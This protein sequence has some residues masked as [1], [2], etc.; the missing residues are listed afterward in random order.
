MINHSVAQLIF[1]VSTV[2]FAICLTNGCSQE[3]QNAVLLRRENLAHLG[4]SYLEWSKVKQSSPGNAEEFTQWMLETDN[5]NIL[6][7]ARNSLIEGDVIMIWNGDLTDEPANA[8]YVVA[9]EAPTPAKGGYVVMGDASVKLMTAKEFA[10]STM[11]P[12][13]Y[14]E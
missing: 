3:Q 7:S 9:F 6:G 10:A 8:G 2:L 13:R 1:P 4:T 11:L 12:Q 5:A 14:Q